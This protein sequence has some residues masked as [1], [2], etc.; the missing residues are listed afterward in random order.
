MQSFTPGKSRGIEIALTAQNGGNIVHGYAKS[1]RVPA[2]MPLRSIHSCYTRL[3][4]QIPACHAEAVFTGAF[5]CLFAEGLFMSGSLL[6]Q[7]AHM[8]N[9]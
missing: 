7:I 2:K 1:I 8:L 9:L 6:K 3:R 4:L 5:F